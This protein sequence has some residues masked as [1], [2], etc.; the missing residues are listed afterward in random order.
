MKE[1]DRLKHMSELGKKTSGE[2][3][4]NWRGEKHITPDGY[5]AIYVPVPHREI[6]GRHRLL[7]HVAIAEKILGRKLKKREMV[8][9]INGI[10]T[11]N[12]NCNL[13]ICTMS[14]HL[15]LHA[16]ASAA[17]GRLCVP[18]IKGDSDASLFR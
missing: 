2:N 13:L 14:Y 1:F 12:R 10:K 17:Y 4:I 5:V 7:E 16:K 11:D 15:F 9:H 6:R 8:H 3:N 18:P